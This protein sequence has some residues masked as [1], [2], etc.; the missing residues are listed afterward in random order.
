M[1]IYNQMEYLLTYRLSVLHCLSLNPLMFESPAG[2][3]LLMGFLLLLQSAL[4][5]ALAC[6]VSS[7]SCSFTISSS[8]SCSVLDEVV[9]F[10]S[11]CSSAARILAH[12]HISFNNSSVYVWISSMEALHFEAKNKGCEFR[13]ASLPYIF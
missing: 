6:R 7:F 1:K 8:T 12:L 9:D 2:L 13:V 4:Q 5:S 10:S 11:V 3:A